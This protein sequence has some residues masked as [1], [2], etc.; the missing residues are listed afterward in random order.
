MKLVKL[1][2]YMRVLLVLLLIALLILPAGGAQADQGD[3]LHAS[4]L[5]LSESIQLSQGVFWSSS[6]NDRITENYIEYI[7]N[8]TIVPI[9]AYGNY[10]YGGNPLSRLN[11]IVANRNQRVIAAF[12]GDYFNMNTRVPISTVIEEGILKGNEGSAWVSV[13]F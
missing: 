1:N 11:E 13:G 12:N 9:I 5:P 10:I 4:N 2:V 6:L 3:L 8:D 7:P